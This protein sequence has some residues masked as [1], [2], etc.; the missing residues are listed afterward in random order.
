[1][2]SMLSIEMGHDHVILL[3]DFS[4]ERYTSICI[5]SG[6][7]FADFITEICIRYGE[8][9]STVQC[10]RTDETIELHY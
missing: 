8:N 7:K 1:M 9:F 5:Y 6:N 4:N 10:S 2:H 3:L